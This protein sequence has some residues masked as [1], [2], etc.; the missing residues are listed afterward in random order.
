MTIDEAKKYVNKKVFIHNFIVFT[1]LLLLFVYLL[2]VFS[3]KGVSSP[4]FI[5]S[6]LVTIFLIVSLFTTKKPIRVYE[7]QSKNV[8]LKNTVILEKAMTK[9]SKYF[10]TLKEEEIDLVSINLS[11]DYEKDVTGKNIPFFEITYRKH[12][13][14]KHLVTNNLVILETNAKENRLRAKVIPFDCV[15]G[16]MQYDL[17][18]I[19]LALTKE[20]IDL[21]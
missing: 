12:G 7:L 10:D 17:Y 11:E 5:I 2:I 3:H 20:T 19:K 6:L 21:I 18:D 8:A 4:E 1:V 14:L 15:F 16:A 9:L 13:T